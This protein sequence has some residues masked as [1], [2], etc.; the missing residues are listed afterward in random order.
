MMRKLFTPGLAGLAAVA[1]G[2][3]LLLG[4]P[5][6][7]E[8]ASANDTLVINATVSARA[9]LTITAAAINF[10]DADPETVL[11]IP[12]NENPVSVTAKV[13]T[14][15]ASTPTLTV[16]TGGPLTSGSDTI[17]ISNVTWTASAAP[18]IA[19]TLSDTVAQNAATFANGSGNYSG[20][21]SFFL[22][23]SWAYNIGSYT[24][25]ATYT[26]TAP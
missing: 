17:A 21:Y 4:A 9:T 23:N 26:L 20:T 13:R 18:F 12:A 6:R 16:I 10:P 22:A 19:G 5:S 1:L 2:A 24:A 14:G 11:S 25:T 7:A 3:A 15:A 8:A